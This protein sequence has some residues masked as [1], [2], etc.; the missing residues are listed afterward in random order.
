MHKNIWVNYSFKNQF[1]V[2]ENISTKL[3]NH[4]VRISSKCQII[5]LKY[6][7]IG[8]KKYGILDTTKTVKSC[9][10]RAF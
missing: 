9:K 7:Y 4:N 3:M 10:F 5:K 2:W 1:S 6:Q 8:F